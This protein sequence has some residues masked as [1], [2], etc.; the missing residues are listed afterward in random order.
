MTG[1]VD[2]ALSWK[3]VTVFKIGNRGGYAAVLREE[4]HR[5]RHAAGGVPEDVE[6]G[7]E[8]G[9]EEV[10]RGWEFGVRGAV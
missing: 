1:G 2:M 8:E 7:S 9:D 5:R 3:D 4:P 10:V 6:G